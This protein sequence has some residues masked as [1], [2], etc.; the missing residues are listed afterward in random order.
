MIYFFTPYS[1]EKKLFEA[2][3]RYMALLPSEDDWACFLD[4][5]TLFFESNFGHQVQEYVDKYPATGMFVSYASRSAYPYMVPAETDQKSDSITYHRSVSSSCYFH[6][7]GH[8]TRIENHVSGH[9]MCI[10]KGTWLEIRQ[11]VGR[12]CEANNLLGV[13]TQITNTML[14]SGKTILLMRGIYLFHYYR[15]AEGKASKK[16][17][18]D[19][20]INV[21]IRTSR[22]PEA[23]TRCLAS[24][25]SQTHKKINFFVSADDDVT[26]DYVQKQEGIT[27]VRVK[28]QLP[29]T[30]LRAPWNLYLNDLMK[31]VKGGW[32]FFLDDDD[33]LADPSVFKRLIP[34]LTD[35][36]RIY[37]VR[38]QW[39][40][41]RVI[42]S[43][44][45]F[46]RHQVVRRDIGMP[47]FIFHARHK[48]KI[49]FRGVKQGDFDFISRLTSVIKHQSWIDLVVTSIC[50]T[51][52]NGK[53]EN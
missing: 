27:I 22:R 25:H 5:D 45:N 1:L 35:E 3:D 4:G 30:E 32:I 42:P 40:N 6:L 53:P 29:T 26:A 49:S 48:H 19:P 44:E 12:R 24:V 34:H 50:N 16:H 23:F 37:F 47:C 51:G 36:N 2:Y 14:G 33:M 38:M 13:D 8:V 41:G 7:H 31:A 52:L 17:L 20:T 28:K 21:L 15:L 11:E 9:L 43:N 10:R 18:M 39:P 46:T